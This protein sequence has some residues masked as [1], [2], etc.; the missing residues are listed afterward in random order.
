MSEALQ[1]CTSVSPR[2]ERL[3][4]YVRDEKL[5]EF[6]LGYIDPKHEV[7]ISVFGCISDT[8]PL[9]QPLVVYIEHQEYQL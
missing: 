2:V 1:V 6:F 5:I 4:A 9:G 7:L 8:G 3:I